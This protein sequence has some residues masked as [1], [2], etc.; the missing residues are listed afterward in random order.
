MLGL[1][2]DEIDVYM[3]L[4]HTPAAPLALSKQ[5][6]IQRT[7]IY[8]L[9][10]QLSKRSLVT[11]QADERGAFYVVSDPL[12]LGIQLGEREV[13]LKEQQ[14]T[15]LRLVPMLDALRG[16][17]RTSSFTI[18]TYEG[19]EGFKQM[20]WHELKTKGEL[21][22]F[23]GGDIEELV[24]DDAWAAKQRERVVE[25]GYR[26]REII[27]SETDLPTFIRNPDYL[28]AYT[29][30]GI[31]AHVVSLE[32][33][34]IIYNDTVAIYNWRNNKK[35]GVEIVSKSFAATM[36]SIFEYFWRLTEPTQTRSN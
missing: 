35:V 27:N 24:P 20:V 3:S 4:L 14:D 17:G 12:N 32:D 7:K 9:L 34:M 1:A 11:R 19:V 13:K 8:S 2:D 21:L 26:V 10:E 29:C 6:G 16:V 15:L 31:S 28:Q 36:R 33:Q 18:R 23:G 22:S 25:A 5:T 30:R